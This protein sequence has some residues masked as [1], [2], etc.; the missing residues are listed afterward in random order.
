LTHEE[1]VASV[2]KLF[3]EDPK[4]LKKIQDDVLKH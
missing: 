3:E 2:K 1:I 4:V